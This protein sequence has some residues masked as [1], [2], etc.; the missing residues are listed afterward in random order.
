MDPHIPTRDEA[1]ALLREFNQTDKAIKHALAVEA[2]MR[3]FA[4]QRNQDV[5]KWGII[6]LIHDLDYEQFPSQH[7]VKTRQI[8]TDRNYPPDYIRAVLSHGFGHCTDVE[9]VHEMEKILFAIDE[10]TGLII[11]ATLVRPSRS[12]DD[13]EVKSVRKKWK[14]K[15]FAAGVDRSV[16]ERGSAMCNIPLDS[17]IAE[18]I[19]ALRPIAAALGLQR[20]TG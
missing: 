13:L 17:L 1:Y 5:E 9:P 2:A 7:C 4:A 19:A 15:S 11:A 16:I 3:H 6:G 20:A 14:E 12:L 18:T 8:L 10:L